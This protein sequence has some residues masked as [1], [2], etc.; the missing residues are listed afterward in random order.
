MKFLEEITKNKKN[1]E[2]KYFILFFAFFS[3]KRRVGL[4]FQCRNEFCMPK[5][6]NKCIFIGFAEVSV[7][8]ANI[9]P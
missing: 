4:C 5:C 1:N 8:S 3:K 7:F 9:C 2:N 6:P